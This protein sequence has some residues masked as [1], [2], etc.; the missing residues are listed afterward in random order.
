MTGKSGWML[1]RS[2]SSGHVSEFSLLRL[3]SSCPLLG[4]RERPWGSSVALGKLR[5]PGPVGQM[6][7]GRRP[8]PCVSHG[9]L[10]CRAGTEAHS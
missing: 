10:S 2:S 5:G 3:D 4:G 1:G 9:L 6:P 7:G 8:C